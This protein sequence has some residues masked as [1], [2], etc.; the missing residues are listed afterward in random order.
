M[1]TARNAPPE[2]LVRAS[3]PPVEDRVV[4]LRDRDERGSL[5]LYSHRPQ[6]GAQAAW[7]KG[8]QSPGFPTAL[9]IESGEG[10]GMGGRGERG[11]EGE[12]GGEGLRRWFPQLCCGRVEDPE[13]TGRSSKVSSF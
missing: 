8:I 1:E 5:K 13:G 9:C 11:W 4:V 2:T 3:L 12:W 10:P 6:W 7:E